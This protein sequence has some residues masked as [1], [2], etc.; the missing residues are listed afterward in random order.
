M[1]API[2]TSEPPDPFD[3]AGLG[4]PGRL[5]RPARLYAIV[6]DRSGHPGP[7]QFL[8]S[9]PEGAAVFALA[10]PGVRFVLHEQG[11][12]SRAAV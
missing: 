7:R 9:L 4:A 6:L 11:A 12:S 8:A 3:L 10:G 2:S 1:N 5:A